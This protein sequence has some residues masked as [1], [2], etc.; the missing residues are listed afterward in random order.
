MVEIR[1]VSFLAGK[2]KI[3]CSRHFYR[4]FV[5]QA[6]HAPSGEGLSGMVKNAVLFALFCLELF[7]SAGADIGSFLVFGVA[8]R[9]LGTVRPIF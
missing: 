1:A 6:I 8:N 3:R 9:R 5:R 2:V 4:L 7:D